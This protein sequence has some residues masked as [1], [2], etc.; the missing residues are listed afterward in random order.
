MNARL[1]LDTRAAKGEA[2][3]KIAIAH[4]KKTAYLHLGIKLLSEQWDAN[5]HEVIKHPNKKEY[6]VFIRNRLSL[7]EKELL[8]LQTMGETSGKSAT[9]IKDMVQCAIDP[10]TRAKKEDSRLFLARF[11]RY[12]SLKTKKKTVKAL[13]W[14][15]DWLSEFDKNLGK[16]SF[17][18]ITSD[19]LKDF[20]AHCQKLSTNSKAIL[21]RNIRAV[22]NDAIDEWITNNYPF[23]RLSIK[24]EKTR[25]KALTLSQLRLLKSY[26]CEEWINEYRDMFFLMFYLRGIN[27]VDLFSAKKS[28]IVNGRLE[29]RRSKV[30][31]L[32]SIKIEPEAQEIISRYGGKDF[33]LNVLDRY[34][35]YEDYL[36]H[37]NAALKKIG[38]ERNKF[39][40]IIGDGLFPELSS[41]WA[42]HSWVTTGINLGISKETM[43]RGAG[44][45][46]GVK[47]TEVYID[48]DMK[49]VD[50]ANRKIIDALKCK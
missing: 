15:I 23:R 45:S 43:S 18:D 13:N 10:D 49:A 3:L 30:G 42:R 12:V 8:R 28:Q 47:V 41:N 40:K 44:H 39:G 48:Y 38:C 20:L 36:H 21:M 4:E 16:R 22:F 34:N 33:L 24:T 14:T 11:K 50:E 2:P 7:V 17:D 25:K 5:T 31:S 26:N 46:F 37:M 1:F 27:A 9:E 32:F 19:Y 35:D 6:N 29:Y